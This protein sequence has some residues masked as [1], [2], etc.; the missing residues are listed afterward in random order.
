VNQGNEK[1]IMSMEFDNFI[2]AIHELG[3]AIA[4]SRLFSIAE[5]YAM[6]RLLHSIAQDND[7][8]LRS[9]GEAHFGQAAGN[10]KLRNGRHALHQ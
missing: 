10:S 1:E 9:I 5:R 3:P 2:T 6:Q 4:D 8:A 7:R